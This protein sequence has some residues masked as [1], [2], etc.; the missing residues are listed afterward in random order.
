MLFNTVNVDERPCN[1][2]CLFSF[3]DGFQIFTFK[4]FCDVNWS[5]GT[6]IPVDMFALLSI[7]FTR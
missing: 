5:G 4:R 2:L 6:K 1:H 7:K 3:I